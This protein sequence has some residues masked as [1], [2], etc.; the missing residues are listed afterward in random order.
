MYALI[1]CVIIQGIALTTGILITH[2][3][4]SGNTFKI[5]LSKRHAGAETLSRPLSK[6]TVLNAP[7]GWDN[8]C[9]QTEVTEKKWGNE[10]RYSWRVKLREQPF[11]VYPDQ[12]LSSWRPHVI[13]LVDDSLGMLNASGY[14]YD[15]S[16]V[17]LRRSEGEIL[18]E[19]DRDDLAGDMSSAE[20]TVF[21]GLYGNTAHPAQDSYH[22][23]GSMQCWSLAHEYLSG[24]IDDL[25]MCP[26]AIA[27]VSKGVV[28]SFTTDRKT[29]LTVLR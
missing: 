3:I 7:E 9:F 23:G 8:A 4:K 6:T 10:V 12:M 24:L 20:G 5:L 22:F 11:Q 26:M 18:P 14:S 21:R 2:D 25:D 28:Q 16:R 17:Y 13:L 15:D 19:K 29:L 1:F 27:T